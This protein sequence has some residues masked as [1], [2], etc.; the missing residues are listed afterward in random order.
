MT[1]Q[2]CLAA[3][4]TIAFGTQPGDESAERSARRLFK[5][6]PASTP[7]ILAESECSEQGTSQRGRCLRVGLRAQHLD[8]RVSELV[9]TRA[10]SNSLAGIVRTYDRRI[11]VGIRRSGLNVRR[12]SSHRARSGH[13]SASDKTCLSTRRH[14]RY[15]RSAKLFRN[16]A[17]LLEPSTEPSIMHTLP[18]WHL[19]GRFRLRE[20][21]SAIPKLLGI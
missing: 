18:F 3:V 20:N 4:L 17:I 13:L 21:N 5:P 2:D 8:M 15:R 7:A 6:T 16:S 9:Q 14:R 19:V 1:I 10:F 11:V 12:E